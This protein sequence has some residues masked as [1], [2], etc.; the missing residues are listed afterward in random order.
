M[1]TGPT[2]LSASFF[3]RLG[4]MSSGPIYLYTFRLMTRWAWACYT[5]IMRGI[6]LPQGLWEVCFNQGHE[7]HGKPEWKWRLRQRSYWSYWP[8]PF[9]HLLKP[10]FSP[11]LSEG[12]HS[13]LPVSS[14]HF[15][16]RIPSCYLS[17]PSLSSIS[18]LVF[19]IPLLHPWIASLYSSQ[20]THSYF[21]CPYTSLF[22]LSL[23]SHDCFLPPFH[24]VLWWR[25][26]NSCAFRKVSL[27]SCQLCSVSTSL[28]TVS[29]GSHPV[30]P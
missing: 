3:R 16:C 20:A 14:D 15:I 9:P 18:A 25:M 28:Q 24:D 2:T 30:I 6:L 11:R 21:H 19:L 1:E 12:A 5:P 29:R 22:S 13:S 27:K 8:Q 23:I 7:R 17:Y 4:C 26:E 10:V